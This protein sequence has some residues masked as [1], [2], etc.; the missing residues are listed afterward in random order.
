[1]YYSESI[2]IIISLLV[3]NIN[4]KMVFFPVS[5]IASK[6]KNQCGLLE[7]YMFSTFVYVFPI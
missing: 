3:T 7:E 5:F 1:M 4:H 6:T 2:G